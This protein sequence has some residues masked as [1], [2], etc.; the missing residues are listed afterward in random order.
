MFRSEPAPST[1]VMSGDTASFIMAPA[2]RAIL[3]SLEPNPA[4]LVRTLSA[5]YSSCLAYDSITV[6]EGRL[7]VVLG[8]MFIVST[9]FFARPPFGLGSRVGKRSSESCA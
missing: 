4:A 3:T 6:A 5:E 8:C 2:L 7:N 1:L 9:P